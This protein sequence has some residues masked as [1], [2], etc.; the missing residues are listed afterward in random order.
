M[1]IVLQLLHDLHEDL[2][3]ELAPT[4]G[5]IHHG[6]GGSLALHLLRRLVVHPDQDVLEILERL[7]LAILGYG[8]ERLGNHLLRV[9]Q[10]LLLLSLESRR[11]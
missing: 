3:S 1:R 8:G 2:V 6:V 9:V 4:L 5:E 11:L 10:V 7:L